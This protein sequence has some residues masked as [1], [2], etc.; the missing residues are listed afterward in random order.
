MTGPRR[1]SRRVFLGRVAVLGGVLSVPSIGLLL[2]GGRGDGTRHLLAHIRSIASA[3]RLGRLYLGQTPSEA[4]VGVIGAILCG[5][6]RRHGDAC[7]GR[8]RQQIARDFRAGDVVTI[9]GWLISRTEAR[10]FALA[11]LASS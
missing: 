4:S 11:A 2:T 5:A 3:R 7:L 1:V 9:D 6:T 10:L 8:V